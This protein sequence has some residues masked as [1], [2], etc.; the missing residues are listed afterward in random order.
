MSAVQASGQSIGMRSIGAALEVSSGVCGTVVLVTV[1][2]SDAPQP[3]ALGNRVP[4]DSQL[5]AQAV[6]VDA[7]P[8]DPAQPAAPQGPGGRA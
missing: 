1:S 6:D 8:A 2:L 7:K 3:G 5:D 4:L